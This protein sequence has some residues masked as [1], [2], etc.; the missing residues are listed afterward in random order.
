MIVQWR[1]KSD[2]AKKSPPKTHDCQERN[3]HKGPGIL[4]DHQSPIHH[5]T[6][7]YTKKIIAIHWRRSKDQAIKEHHW[8]WQRQQQ[9]QHD[10]STI[11]RI[12]KWSIVFRS[13]TKSI[14]NS[15]V[16]PIQYH[17]HE[18]ISQSRR[19]PN[20]E[21]CTPHRRSL[22]IEREGKRLP[23]SSTF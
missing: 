2:Q 7:F 10:V 20:G 9:Q 15:R 16:K 18:K 12:S 14:V 1:E 11:V 5:L 13:F 21:S 23:A 22:L 8:F 3:D 19:K 6:T 17:Q 4:Q